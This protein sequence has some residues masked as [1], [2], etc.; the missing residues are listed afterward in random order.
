MSRQTY[1]CVQCRRRM[2]APALDRAP[3]CCGQSAVALD[4]AQCMLAAAA[5]HSRLEDLDEP[6]DDGRAG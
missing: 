1:E 6:C 2:N 4:L 3:E 5:E